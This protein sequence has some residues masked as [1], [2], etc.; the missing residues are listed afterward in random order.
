[1]HPP[2]PRDF[3]EEGSGGTI[4]I[5]IRQ[6]PI[7]D[8]PERIK[9]PQEDIGIWISKK[10]LDHVKTW[11][12]KFNLA[13]GMNR[14][15][16]DKLECNLHVTEYNETG[17]AYPIK[18]EDGY[19]LKV[20]LHHSPR[21]VG[22]VRIFAP[23]NFDYKTIFQD[24]YFKI[25]HFL[26]P[27]EHQILLNAMFNEDTGTK[28]YY[29]EL[30]N[31]IGPKKTVDEK[32]KGARLSCHMNDGNG[33]K[34]WVDVVIDY[35]KGP[36]IEFKGKEQPTRLT[37]DITVDPL[38]MAD[39]IMSM[40]NHLTSNQRLLFEGISENGQSL[41][42]IQKNIDINHQETSADIS[43]LSAQVFGLDIG[44]SSHQAKSNKILKSI[45][46]SCETNAINVGQTAL[47]IDETSQ[48]IVEKIGNKV[49]DLDLDINSGLNVLG[50]KIDKI[51]EKMDRQLMEIKQVIETEFKETKERIKNYFYLIL[52]KVD[53][54][55]GLTIRELVTHLE[56]PRT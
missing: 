48:T 26:T 55:P 54:I 18:E 19:L 40:N 43:E 5:D 17:W 52:K 4:S 12:G 45:L 36:E 56:M 25:F 37:R 41:Q 31:A 22:T 13:I 29:V 9:K 42:L 20:H 14:Q 27:E 35:S 38:K 46:K 33:G 16:F 49:D 47:L 34:T 50:S 21:N 6:V 10:N 32:L 30:A 15:L 24:A 8:V 44:L 28:M 23:R 39:S 3:G 2:F 53:N 7:R 1:L 11:N 51:D